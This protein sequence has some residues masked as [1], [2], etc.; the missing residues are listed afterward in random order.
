MDVAKRVRR[1]DTDDLIGG[2][3]DIGHQN[4]LENST[5]LIADLRI[6][7]TFK[8]EAKEKGASVTDLMLSALRL[9]REDI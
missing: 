9:L 2:I 8:D 6:N 5:P 7:Q 3:R 1:L 4:N